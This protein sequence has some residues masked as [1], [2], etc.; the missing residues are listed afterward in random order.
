MRHWRRDRRALRRFVPLLKTDDGVILGAARLEQVVQCL[1]CERLQARVLVKRASGSLVPSFDGCDD[2]VGVVGP[3]K[4]L[5]VCIGI[6]EEVVDG[7]FEFLEGSEH[8]ALEA[9]F[10][11]FGK[12]AFDGIEPGG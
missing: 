4:G 10:G 1:G 3:G 2:F 8:A 9:L 7:V 12:E 11:E 6:V 5:W